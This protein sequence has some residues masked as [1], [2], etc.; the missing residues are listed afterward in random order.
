MSQPEKVSVA[1]DCGARLRVPPQ[2]VDRKAKCPKCGQFT[3]LRAV[4]D[5]AAPRGGHGRPPRPAPA[6][7]AARD[8]IRLDC[9]CGKRIAVPASAAGRKARCPQCKATVTIPGAAPVDALDLS[10]LSRGDAVPEDELLRIAPVEDTPR[11]SSMV[12]PADLGPPRKCPICKREWP[13]RAIICT[14]CGVDLKTGRSPLKSQEDSLN[15]AYATTDALVPA[16]SYISWLGIWPVASEAYGRF[17]PWVTRGIALLTTIV[18]CWYMVVFLFA[19]WFNIDPDPEH[20]RL[21]L[22][23]GDVDAL[24]AAVETEAD[25]PN[26]AAG[27]TADGRLEPNA[28]PRM[29]MAAQLADMKSQ[30]EFME[31][32]PYQLI[33]HMFLHGDLFHLIGNLI[34]L[35]VLGSR[36]N[37]LIGNVLTLIL[38]PL[39]GIA[40]AL[41]EL[42]AHEG[43]FPSALIGASGAI[44]G[45]AG[46]YLVFFPVHKVH[47]AAWLRFTLFHYSSTIFS[48]RG[49]WVVL[50]YISFDVL[51]TILGAEDGVAHWA[52][53]G[54]FIVGMAVALALLFARVVNAR[55]GDIISVILGHRARALVGMPNRKELPLW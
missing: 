17:T 18:S 34:F 12:M 6:P 44:M 31:Y 47:V 50:F 16:I 24:V 51:F 48:M 28:I 32:H 39:L 22:W 20:M 27:Q 2:A 19:G 23:G 55:G 25:D 45:L 11:E 8:Q 7:V 9:A 41:A 15:Q 40:A 1:C 13:S 30:A 35:I 36:V 21:M 49:F 53:L 43:G 10:S 37:A 33:S 52:H 38:Y 29:V 46:M 26:S 5:A 54:G 3:R 42:A 4:E 14:D